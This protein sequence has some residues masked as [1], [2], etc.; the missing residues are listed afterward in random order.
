M[1]ITFRYCQGIYH[2]LMMQFLQNG[3]I[4]KF[5]VTHLQLSMEDIII[6]HKS[7]WFFFSLQISLLL[8]MYFPLITLFFLTIL[9][10]IFLRYCYIYSN[11]LACTISCF[12]LQSRSYLLYTQPPSPTSLGVKFNNQKIQTWYWS[13][14][15]VV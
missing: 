7:W 4:L 13:I 9:V 3:K 2:E 12:L 8:K 15:V 1:W 5:T 14:L 6:L 11:F 10:L